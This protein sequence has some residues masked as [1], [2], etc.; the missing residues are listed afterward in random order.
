MLF[1]TKTERRSNPLSDAGIKLFLNNLEE[2]KD[3]NDDTDKAV[4]TYK[5]AYD[6]DNPANQRNTG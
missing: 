6:A 4:Q 5:A 3:G 2:N 1:K